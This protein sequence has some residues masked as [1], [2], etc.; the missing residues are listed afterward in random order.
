MKKQLAHVEEFHKAFNCPVRQSPTLIP[1]DEAVLRYDLMREEN[2]EYMHA[3]NTNDLVEVAD[4]L[5]DQLYILCGTIISH[6]M[7]DIIEKVFEEIQ[8]SNM[9]KL[10][11]NGQPII[12]GQNGVFDESRP[13]GKVIK[14]SNFRQPNLA[15]IIAGK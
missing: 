2:D 7:Q 10:D 8:T 9:S 12:N 4:A 11:D 15:P 3:I 6:G 13:L 5:G 14:S 1:I